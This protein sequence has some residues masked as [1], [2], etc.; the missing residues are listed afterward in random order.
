MP[1][2]LLVLAAASSVQFGAAIAATLFDDLGPAGA[3]VMRVGLGAVILL[4]VWRPRV[5]GLARADLWLVFWLGLTL[6]V[7]NFT[8]YEALDRIPLGIAVTIEFAGPLGLA[9]ALSRRRLDLI[10]VA[11]AAVGIVLLADPGGGGLDP[12]GLVLVL[13]AA[14]AWALYILLAARAGARFTGG[15]GLALAMIVASLVPL[16]PGIAQAGG[17]LLSPEFLAIGAAVALLSSVIPYSLEME[18]LRRIPRHV[19]GVL[20]SLEPALAALA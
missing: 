10:W 8:F 4:L 20:M 3:S 9:V 2:P 16:V 6:G 13:V 11:L 17:D 14:A 1:A 18:A 19:F 15:R 5:R 12:V 7:M